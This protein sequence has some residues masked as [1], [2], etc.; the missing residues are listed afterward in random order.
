[1]TWDTA[2]VFAVLAGAIALFASDRVRLDLVAL[3]VLLALLLSG[4]LTVGEALAGFSQSVVMMVAG[5]FVVGEGL[6]RTGIAHRMG[7]LLIKVGRDHVGRLTVWLMAAV[8]IIGAFMSSTGI[9]AIF[10]PVALGI[11]MRSG[12]EPGRLMMPLA[13]AALISGM[14]SL[15]STAP[16]LVAS[17][18]L[19][20]AG[21]EP[22]GF[23][24]FTP[25]GVAVLIVGILYMTTLGRRLLTVRSD[26]NKPA[27]VRRSMQELAE[28]YGVADRF[29]R[30]RIGPGSPLVGQTVALAEI[31]TTHGVVVVAVDPAGAGPGRL[32]PALPRTLFRAGDT[33]YVFASPERLAAFIETQGLDELPIPDALSRQ[34]LQEGGLAEVLIPPESRLVGRTLQQAALRSRHRLTVT[35]IRR[36]G[37]PLDD[38]VATEPLAVGD[39]LL[40]AGT[41]SHIARLQT[42]PQDFVVLSLPQE[43]ADA[44]PAHRRAPAALGILAAMIA[45]MVTGIVPNAAAVLLAAVAMVVAG[46]VTMDGGYRSVSWQTIV[47]IAGMLPLATALDRTGGT[48][49][50]VHGLVA[51]LGDAGPYAMMAGLFV[52]TSGLGSFM[53]NTATAV[54]LS[55]V[56]I[57]IALD[58]GVSPHSFAMT[59]AIAA[60]AAFSTPVSS[61]VVTLVVEPGSYRFMDFVRVGVPMTV[62]VLVVTLALLPILFPLYP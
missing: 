27:T 9:V 17:A 56:A 30:L 38:D 55:P 47:L 42:D 37:R 29:R 58:M 52:L 59:V 35:A 34:L 32:V 14:M 53:S 31:R 16:N 62:L 21:Y 48:D 61:P 5:L 7:S 43:M 44:A 20:D 25:I 60:S 2:F 18:A 57:G 4:I 49:L 50:I 36:R 54:L 15:I 51:G 45:A 3:L 8:A 39:T 19:V 26:P 22:F 12:I 6:V 24:D 40:V 13:F 11:A 10:I 23:F 28:A 33:V 41:W 46:C 1:M